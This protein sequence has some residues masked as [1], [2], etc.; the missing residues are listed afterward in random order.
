M[1]M[2]RALLIFLA[3]TT[4]YTSCALQA[5]EPRQL[6]SEQDK[7]RTV[8]IFHHPIVMLQ[9]KFGLTTPEERVLRIRQTLRS[10]S[11]EDI[12]QPVQILTVK[13]YNQQARL[14]TINGK[15]LMLLAEGDLDEGD[16][17]T[18]DQA[19]QRVLTRMDE[20]RTSLRDQYSS[21]Y[22]ALATVKTAIGTLAL[23]LLFY[24]A[25]RSWRRVKRYFEARVSHKKGIIPAK[26]R[27]LVGAVEGYLYGLLMILLGIAAFYV[28]LSWVFRLFPWTRVWGESLGD[29]SINVIQKI[30]LS[31]VSAFPGLMI[32]LIIFLITA[33]ILKLLKILLK[34]V[35]SGKLTL[36]G[37]H[38]ETVGATR[39]LIS[40]MVWLFALSAAYPFLPGADS[41]AFKGISVFFGLMLTLGSAG[42]MNHAMSGLVL[43]YSRALRKGDVIRI[44]D[45]E[46]LV[47]EVGMLATKIVTRENYI[48]TVPN[49]VVV[50]G[51][52]TNLSSQNPGGGVNLTTSVTIGYDT[53]WRQVHAMLELAAKRTKGIEQN[54]PPLVR[55]LNLM[56]WYIAYELQ[57]K[58]R[59]G[60]SL[61]GVKS[62]LHSHIQDVFNEFNVQIMSPNFVN[63][64][65]NAVMVTRDNW[66]TAPAI[67]PDKAP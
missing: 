64:P 40:V 61:A 52:I 16:D 9:A 53:P 13:R 43:T 18:L 62:E 63:Q 1:N 27:E 24:A 46:G 66:F 58:L 67:Q 7:A 8:Y 57:V 41:V 48:V 49:A 37:L 65:E 25:F 26:W 55:Q 36:P 47:N 59:P 38:P 54:T 35:E 19:A 20:Q 45:N 34:R 17:L 44:G 15:P 23:G 4:L 29:W 60:E 30:A 39:K 50:S 14:F 10:L 12:R 28:W 42:V 56:D 2:I 6:P 32:V 22:L 11:E 21:S 3:W 31:I 5:A 33:F 51:K